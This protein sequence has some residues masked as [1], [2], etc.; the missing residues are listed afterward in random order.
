MP[1]TDTLYETKFYSRAELVKN[2]YKLDIPNIEVMDLVYIEADSTN[3][4]Y[5]DS[6]QY[7]ALPR[8]CY[9]TSTDDVE[10]WH[11][12]IES[13][14]DSLNV[15]SKTA[16]ISKM[17]T[18]TQSVTKRNALALGLE[19]SYMNKASIP[20]YLEYSHLLHKN[21]SFYARVYYDVPTM[22][23]GFGLGA[24]VSIGW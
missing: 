16:I 20:I 14:I 5:K 21:A 19:M 24:K 11:S 4:I 7:I 13:T 23:Y 9:Y 8:E 2:T 22:I 12:G 1:Q 10:I 6:I 15:L 3:I 17:E 18:V